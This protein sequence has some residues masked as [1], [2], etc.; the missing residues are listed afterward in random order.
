MWVAKVTKFHYFHETEFC[1]NVTLFI[2]RLICGQGQGN[3]PL[4]SLHLFWNGFLFVPLGFINLAESQVILMPSHLGSNEIIFFVTRVIFTQR[5]EVFMINVYITQHCVLFG[6]IILNNW[7]S[8]LPKK[9]EVFF[10]HH[11]EY[12][13]DHFESFWFLVSKIFA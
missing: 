2:Q 6:S 10:S 8:E 7:I 3:W 11:S 1:Q 12:F 4:P 5:Y 9:V 13:R